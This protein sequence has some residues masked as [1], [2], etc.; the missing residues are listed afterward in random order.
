MSSE[1][2]DNYLAANHS[3]SWKQ[4]LTKKTRLPPMNLVVVLSELLTV[5][6]FCQI[7]C[8]SSIF[9]LNVNTISLSENQPLCP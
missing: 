9:D 5:Q 2:E 7:I 1:T 6:Y 8:T 3:E 4:S